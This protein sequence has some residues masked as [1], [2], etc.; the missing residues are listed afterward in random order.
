MS[1]VVE[2]IGRAV[3]AAVSLP[4]IYG[5]EKDLMQIRRI[6]ETCAVH[7][8]ARAVFLACRFRMQS[9]ANKRMAKKTWKIENRLIRSWGNRAAREK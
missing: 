8:N 3:L 7:P 1:G 5:L 9:Y 6:P 2:R 4:H